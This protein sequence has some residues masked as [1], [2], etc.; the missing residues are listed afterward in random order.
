MAF[1]DAT[2][3]RR[4]ARTLLTPRLLA[5][6]ALCLTLLAA[7]NVHAQEAVGE[8]ELERF[9]LRVSDGKQLFEM[10]KF[11]A[12]IEQFQ[13]AR[14][15]YDHPRLTF[16][17]AQAYKSLGACGESREAFSRYLGYP[18]LDE[19]MRERAA[20]LRD[21][22]DTTC[23]EVGRLRVSCAPADATLSLTRLDASTA[24]AQ[25]TLRACPLDT[26][27]RTGVWEIQA[28]APG[29]DA[30]H[31]Q[32]EVTRDATQSLHLTL[33]RQPT[34]AGTPTHKILAYS[35][36]GVGGLGL[37]SGIISDFSAVSRLDELSAAQKRADRSRID[38]LQAEAD[39][40]QIRTAILYSVGALATAAGVL[41]L[42]L[43]PDSAAEGSD[44]T[45][46]AGATRTSDAKASSFSV[47]FGPAGVRTQFR[48]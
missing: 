23:V 28:E 34:P 7:P 48:W 26:E 30:T 24:P 42:V 36:I 27:I 44:D 10:G 17:I 21:Q 4:T 39:S 12:A 47:D 8:E 5:L 25:P 32:F 37:V 46:A 40:A 45:R 19:Q 41:W 43:Q 31:Q 22:L 15:I 9:K 38:A 1:S 33:S 18:D 11:R 3:R 20:Q 16:N 6:S 29:Y 35:L 2:T 14:D 13:A